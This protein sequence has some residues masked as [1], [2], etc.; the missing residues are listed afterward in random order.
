M[1][2]ADSEKSNL[3]VMRTICFQKFEKNVPSSEFLTPKTNLI[4]KRKSGALTIVRK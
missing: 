1:R 3:E 2:K 4:I